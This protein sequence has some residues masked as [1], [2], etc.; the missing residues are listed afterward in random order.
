MVQIQ[1][2]EGHGVENPPPRSFWCGLHA[3]ACRYVTWDEPLRKETNAEDILHTTQH[4]PCGLR[5]EHTWQKRRTHMTRDQQIWKKNNTMKENQGT[6]VT[7]EAKT[8][9]RYEQ[10]P[11]RVKMSYTHVKRDQHTKKGNYQYV[12][13]DIQHIYVYTYIVYTYIYSHIQRD[14]QQRNRDKTKHPS[15]HLH[16]CDTSSVQSSRHSLSKSSGHLAKKLINQ[17]F[18]HFIWWIYQ[19]SNQSNR[20]TNLI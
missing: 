20:D 15:A 14:I 18:C 16:T 12:Q 19:S 17:R 8:R 2:R 13:R 1:T 5:D 10:R 11:T 9:Q 6:D 3:E 7:R 4:T